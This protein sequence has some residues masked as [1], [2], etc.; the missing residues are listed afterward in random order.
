MESGES[1]TSHIR[2]RTNA[3]KYAERE[4]IVELPESSYRSIDWTVLSGTL[5][6]EKRACHYGIVWP[7]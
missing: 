5:V 6:G 2:E 3:E 7:A 4:E 1:V